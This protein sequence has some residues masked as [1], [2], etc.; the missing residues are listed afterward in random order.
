MWRVL[1]Y[2]W[3]TNTHTY[4]Y[5]HSYSQPKAAWSK[6]QAGQLFLSSQL[7]R[8]DRKNRK[9]RKKLSSVNC[10]DMPLSYCKHIDNYLP[11]ITYDSWSCPLF[12]LP[13]GL[14][15]GNLGSG[16]WVLGSGFLSILSPLTL[17]LCVSQPTSAS[18][19]TILLSPPSSICGESLMK[20]P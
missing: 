5:T 8:K 1:E 18:R 9:N 20:V 14:R 6:R 15:F 10:V 7:A 4:T 17:C 3:D 16:F 13:F 11:L 19:L 2:F 12:L